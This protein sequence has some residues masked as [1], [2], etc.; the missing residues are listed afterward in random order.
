M[1]RDRPQ[2]EQTLETGDSVLSGVITASDLYPNSSKVDLPQILCT[3]NYE[4]TLITLAWINLLLQLSG[5]P[6][7]RLHFE[8]ILRNSFCS[9]YLRQKIERKGLTEHL[10]F[11]TESTLRLLSE[12]ARVAD[13]RSRRDPSP[14]AHDAD[15]RHALARCYL[16]ANESIGANIPDAVAT[17]ERTEEQRKAFLV[18]FIPGQ[19]YAVRYYSGSVRFRYMMVRSKEFLT[20]F[21]EI[22]CPIDVDETVSKA[23]GLTLEDYQNL[24]FSILAV[25]LSSGERGPLIDIKGNPSLTP[26][27]NKLLPHACISIDDLACEAAKPRYL[28]N[29]FLLWKEKPLVKISEAA[30]MCIDFHFLADKL[31][32]GVFWLI[33][34][35]L[36]KEKKG[37]GKKIIDLRGGVFEDYTASII[38]RTL[39]DVKIQTADDAEGYIINPTYTQK[40]QVECTDIA[41]CGS[42]TL[43]LLEC[44]APLLSAETKLSSDF[45]K[46]YNGIKPNAIKGIKQLWKAIQTLGHTNQE[47]RGRIEGIDIFKV[48]KIYPVLVLSDSIF[49]LPEMNWLLDLE[50]Q[51]FVQRNDLEDHLDIMPLT[52]LTI[53]DLEFLE[54]YLSDTPFHVHLEKWIQIATRNRQHNGCPF[55]EYLRRL[56]DRGV[57]QNT[58]IDQEFSKIRDNIKDYFSSHFG[59]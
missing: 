7:E 20:R 23:T 24:I 37:E 59:T 46:F 32:T 55:S 51:R 12:S 35:Q 2:T 44:K 34:N 18:G 47:K 16:S 9:P 14:D 1:K 36:E 22:D 38:K 49:S 5:T 28:T 58:Y 6:S 30:M 29:D 54:P 39:P 25:H 45:S 57:R 3:F 21:R 33:R 41:I 31:E 53:E 19:E 52:V 11:N 10:L 4:K 8:R 15:A 13:P 50:F 26:L 27:Y 40:K 56:R 42:E 17:E 48:K 43:I